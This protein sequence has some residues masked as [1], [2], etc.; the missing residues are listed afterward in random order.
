MPTKPTAKKSGRGRR[1][2]LFTKDQ[3]AEAITEAGGF[4]TTAAERLGCARSTV[5][6]YVERY[7][8]LGAVV[9]EAREASI[10]LAESKLMEAIKDGP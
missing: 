6:D 3:V 5:Y 8:E 7:A 9:H 10:D 4:I 1:P 2:E